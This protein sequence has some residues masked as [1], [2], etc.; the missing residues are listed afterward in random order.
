[1]RS[2]ARVASARQDTARTLDEA[3]ARAS[4]PLAIRHGRRLQYGA[5]ELTRPPMDPASGRN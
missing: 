3:C 5:L 1:M 4:H 2:A